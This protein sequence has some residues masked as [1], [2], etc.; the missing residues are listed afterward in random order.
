MIYRGIINFDFTDADGNQQTR[1]SLALREVG[2]IHVE[3]S[4]FFRESTSLD[5]IWE[6]I[7]LV[8]RQAAVVGSLS[9]L[10]FHVQAA[11]IDFQS[12]VPLKSTQSP[13]NAVSDIKSRPFP[14]G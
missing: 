3:T 11:S 12:S 13:A 5:D 1:L 7:G 8:A 2:W 9:A 14:K 4:A 6:G 10:T